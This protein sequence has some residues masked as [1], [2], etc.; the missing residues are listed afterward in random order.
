MLEEV[1]VTSWAPELTFRA[2]FCTVI[3][4]DIFAILF[5]LEELQGG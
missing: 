1:T 3:L 2:F 4:V 5:F